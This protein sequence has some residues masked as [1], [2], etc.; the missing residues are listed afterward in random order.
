MNL[1]F[2]TFKLWEEGVQK[3]HATKGLIKKWTK[4]DF[5]NAAHLKSKFTT[6]Y[7]LCR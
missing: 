2:E 5:I 4:S 6:I 1:L 7:N 3:V